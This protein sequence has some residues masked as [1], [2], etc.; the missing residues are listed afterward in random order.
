MS[1]EEV[2]ISRETKP[3]VQTVAGTLRHVTETVL[4]ASGL[5]DENLSGGSAAQR[6]RATAGTCLYPTPN[7]RDITRL[8]CSR[9]RVRE[10]VGLE[11]VAQRGFQ[12]LPRGSGRDAI[13]EHDV[14][15]HPP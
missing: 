8:R 1:S 12:E 5:M 14:I 13:D 3:S 2:S 6:C 15:E 10:R 7:G 4:P 11:L 9:R